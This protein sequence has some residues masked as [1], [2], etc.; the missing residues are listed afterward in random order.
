MLYVHEMTLKKALDWST[1]TQK[2]SS[3]FFLFLSFFSFSFSSF[4]QPPK[5]QNLPARRAQTRKDVKWQVHSSQKSRAITENWELIKNWSVLNQF[6]VL[7]NRSAFLW[8]VNLSLDILSG[9]G[10]AR[11]QILTFRG[12]WKRR[13]RKRKKRKKKKEKRRFFLSFC[14][15]I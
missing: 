2:K 1:K 8:T 11:G 3:F 10:A 14:W 5:G 12:L 15:S 6:S 9:L 7:S 13:K 4:S